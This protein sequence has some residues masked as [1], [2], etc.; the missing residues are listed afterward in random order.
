M[1]YTHY[2]LLFFIAIAC[3]SEKT[4]DEKPI[5]RVYNENLYLSDLKNVLNGIKSKDDS[6]NLIK[7]FIDKWAKKQVLLHLAEINL[8]DEDKDVSEEL[9]NYKTSL[10]IY[11]YQQNFINQKLDTIITEQELS[12]YYNSHP[13]EFELEENIVKANF[14]EIPKSAPNIQILKSL[15]TKTNEKDLLKLDKYCNKYALVYENFNDRWFSFNKLL[16][17]LPIEILDQEA[18]LKSNKQIELKAP[19]YFYFAFI[20]EY[21]LAGTPAPVEFATNLIAPI[22]LTKRKIELFNKLENNA[23]KEELNKNNVEIY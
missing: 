4:T 16:K 8:S 20:K 21:Q 17:L 10:L 1:K 13:N 11:K 5:A 15:Y 14:I 9:D 18:F 7:N 6:I 23:L 2:I 12:N 22:I 19:N 3:S